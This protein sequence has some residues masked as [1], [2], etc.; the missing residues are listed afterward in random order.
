MGSGRLCS[1]G[2]ISRFER[3]S[4]KLEGPDSPSGVILDSFGFSG[5]HLAVR[6]RSGE[7]K[8]QGGA[9]G[10]PIMQV[11]GW[12]EPGGFKDAGGNPRVIEGLL[13]AQAVAGSFQRL[14]VG[15][16]LGESALLA[17]GEERRCSLVIG[18]FGLTAG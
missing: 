4:R 6:V 18:S 7:A 9:G 17:F 1:S 12:G 5:Q 16:K 2:K 15:S 10:G 11:D 3:G 14:N 13:G 8:G